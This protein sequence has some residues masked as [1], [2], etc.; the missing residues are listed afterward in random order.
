MIGPKLNDLGD[1]EQRQLSHKKLKLRAPLS[2]DRVFLELLTT[3]F[4]VNFQLTGGFGKSVLESF[5]SG[6]PCFVC[7]PSYT[8]ILPDD[9]QLFVL[10][11]DAEDIS[12]KLKTLWRF[13]QEEWRALL[14]Q[15][16]QVV[17]EKHS[18]HNILQRI[19]EQAK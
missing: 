10:C 11:H 14:I 16:H 8:E 18:V 7:D 5:G 17:W 2:G 3:D 12:E 6:V 15:L 13:S 19:V 9:Y 1:T 4:T